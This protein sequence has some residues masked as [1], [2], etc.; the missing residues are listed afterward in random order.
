[1][2]FFGVAA[3]VVIDMVVVVFSACQLCFPHKAVVFCKTRRRSVV[4]H[5]QAH[6]NRFYS[7][8][9]LSHGGI[10][11]HPVG[12]ETNMTT[13]QLLKTAPVSGGR[14]YQGYVSPGMVLGMSWVLVAVYFFGSF[15]PPLFFFPF[16]AF[17][18]LLSLPPIIARD[19]D[20][21]SYSR[22]AC[23]FPTTYGY[24]T[25]PHFIASRLALSSLIDS[26][27]IGIAALRIY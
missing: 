10:K 23:P 6:P 11:P 17:P 5:T 25:Y 13:Q 27:L 3:V 19:S 8:V 14:S 26:R 1:M 9:K 20:P 16:I 2:S 12:D 4:P 18:V 15:P 7:S 22:L 24:V 21:R